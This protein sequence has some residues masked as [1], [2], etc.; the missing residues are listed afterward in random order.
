MV[1]FLLVVVFCITIIVMIIV[2]VATVVVV[3]VVVAVIVATVVVGVVDIVPWLHRGVTAR[4][5]HGRNR[6]ALTRAKGARRH[7]LVGEGAPGTASLAL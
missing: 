6:A 1:L 2:I 4:R 7:A 3:T 5:R